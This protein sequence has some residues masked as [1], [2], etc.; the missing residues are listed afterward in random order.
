MAR[1][2]DA[3]CR[4]CRR[5]GERLFLKGTRCHTAKCAV[6]KR[7]Y[8][9]GRVSFRRGRLSDYGVRLREKQKTKRIYGVMEKKFRSYFSEAE[10][11]KGNTGENL[12]VLLERRLDNVIYSLGFA[13]SRAQ[14]RQM[15]AHG[16][17]YVDGKKVDIPSYLVRVGQT[18]TPSGRKKSQDFMRERMESR[19]GDTVPSWLAADEKKLEGKVVQLPTRE[20]VVLPIQES[21]IVEFCSR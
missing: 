10:R 3:K 20:D 13:E 8:P 4:L 15:I 7:A 6:A 21:F 9:P 14:A 17:V 11:V 19:K 18:I 5:E 12:L 16:H 1:Y 2:T